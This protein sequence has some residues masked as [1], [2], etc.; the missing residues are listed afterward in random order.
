M[1]QIGLKKPIET[2]FRGANTLDSSLLNECFAKDAVVQDE[3]QE[4]RGIAAVLEWIEETHKKYNH[5]MEVIA[6]YEA[7]GQ[8]EVTALVTGNFEGSPANLNFRFTVVNEKITSLQ[9]G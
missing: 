9:C 5:T 4:Y 3:G 1:E 8:T 7:A 6:A 2:Y